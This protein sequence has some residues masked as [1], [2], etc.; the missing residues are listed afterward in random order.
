M[1]TLAGVYLLGGITLLSELE[2][3][4]LS[5]I[6]HEQQTPHPV[7]LRFGNVPTHLADAVKLDPYHSASATQYLLCIPGV[8]RYLVTKGSEILVAP[9]T[10]ALQGDVRAYLLGSVFVVLCQQRGLLPLHAS[11]VRG[12]S[13][14]MAFVGNSGQGKSTLAAHLGRRGFHVVAD[15]ICL[16]DTEKPGLAKVTPTAPWLKLWRNSLDT[17]GTQ[18]EGLVKVFSDDDKYRLPIAVPS[19]QEPIRK[20][21]FLETREQSSESSVTIMENISRLEALPLLMSLVHHAWLLE[22]TGQR[23][24]TFLRCSRILSQATAHRLIR[25][26]GL[27]HLESTVNL[28]ES[29]MSEH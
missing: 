10:S 3:P 18:A 28:L 7:L 15:D 2:L 17:L 8:A 6:Q 26:W 20:L 22:A 19:Q 27:N 11:A 1:T 25:P 24:E 21:F 16:V 4:E 9:D 14:V 12:K 23:E 29:F 5:T 13:G